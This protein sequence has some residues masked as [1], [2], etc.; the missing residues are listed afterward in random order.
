MLQRRDRGRR[1]VLAVTYRVASTQDEL[2]AEDVYDRQQEE[3]ASP[4]LPAETAQYERHGDAECAGGCRRR[5]RRQL[6]RDHDPVLRSGS[7]ISARFE[8]Q[9]AESCDR[10]PQRP[11]LRRHAAAK[12]LGPTISVF[13]SSDYRSD[14]GIEPGHHRGRILPSVDTTGAERGPVS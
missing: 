11:R 8:G 7:Y 4:G 3:P 2:V 6:R 12:L 9:P 1:R 10:G 13:A 14:T 5:R